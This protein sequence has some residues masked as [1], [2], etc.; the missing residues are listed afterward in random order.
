MR[1][2]GLTI[3][4]VAKGA[5]VH[6]AVVRYYGLRGLLPAA[7]RRAGEW[8]RYPHG[9]V[10]RMRFIWRARALGFSL[11]EIA[12]LLELEDG[13]NRRRVQ[14]IAAASLKEIRRRIVDL[15]RT[16]RG[17]ARLLRESKRHGKF[18]RSSLIFAIALVRDPGASGIPAT[19]RRGRR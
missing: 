18:T 4:D 11:A 12:A 9:T 2:D 14:R 8:R 16:E 1:E 19:A 5:R 7:T 3:G 17:L 6:E 15:Q 10:E 13:T